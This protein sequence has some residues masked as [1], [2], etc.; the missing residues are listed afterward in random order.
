M[1]QRPSFVTPHWHLCQIPGTR[2]GQ[3]GSVGGRFVPH[4]DIGGH[5]VRVAAER[6]G[7]VL[8]DQHLAAHHVAIVRQAD[9]VLRHVDVAFVAVFKVHIEVFLLEE[10]FTTQAAGPLAR[11]VL[12]LGYLLRSEDV[13]QRMER[14]FQRQFDLVLLQYGQPFRLDYLAHH[15]GAVAGAGYLEHAR[16]RPWDDR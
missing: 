8:G 13:A 3:G 2:S 12:L 5:H 16:T 10:T 6:K 1:N 14:T 11:A 15:S 7:C 9:G 4:L